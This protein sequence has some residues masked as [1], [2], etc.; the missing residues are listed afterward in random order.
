MTG[1]NCFNITIC[2]SD[3]VL[4]SSFL[5][6]V[7]AAFCGIDPYSLF[8][9]SKNLSP[10]LNMLTSLNCDPLHHNC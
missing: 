2:K 6:V 5:L 3:F 8:N 9:L 7:R 4:L 1:N 10:G